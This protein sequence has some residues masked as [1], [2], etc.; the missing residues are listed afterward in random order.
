MPSSI[1]LNF[2]GACSLSFLETLS[3]CPLALAHPLFIAQ[4][5]EYL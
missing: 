5:I 4:F 3:A 1:P 2:P